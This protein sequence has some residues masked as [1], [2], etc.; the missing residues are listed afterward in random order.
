MKKEFRI[1][2]LDHILASYFRVRAFAFA[3][4]VRET[5]VEVVQLLFFAYIEKYF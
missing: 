2:L 5:I 1:N 4:D 3:K